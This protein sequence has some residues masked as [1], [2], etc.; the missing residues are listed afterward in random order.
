MCV[1]RE[2]CRGADTCARTWLCARTGADTCACTGK[3]VQGWGCT[4]VCARGGVCKDRLHMCVRGHGRVQGCGC[5]R[6]CVDTWMC[7]GM[8]LHTHVRVHVEV[9]KAACMARCVCWV[10]VAHACARTRG[11]A[12]MGLHTRVCI[13][14]GTEDTCVRVRMGCTRVCASRRVQQ[15]RSHT[16]VSLY[17]HSYVHTRV[18]ARGCGP[19]CVCAWLGALERAR[20]MRAWAH[21]RV[22]V[23][24]AATRAGTCLHTRVQGCSGRGR[25]YTGCGR[26]HARSVPHAPHPPCTMHR[27][28]HAPCAASHLRAACCAASPMHRALLGPCS[29]RCTAAVHAPGVA[30]PMQRC[31]ELP[32]PHALP[33]PCA[34]PMHFWAPARCMPH[35]AA[36]ARCTALHVRDASHCPCRVHSTDHACA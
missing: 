14:H 7:A 16:C 29:V 27:I 5:T 26:G 10:G 31:A 13:A 35:R 25:G 8:C 21:T 20:G 6:V 17:A 1:H 33:C 30:S 2:V 4:R 22:R 9:C 24:A 3:C 15:L 11:C 34:C 23:A 28:P 12:R 19:G 36:P 18:Q 32:V